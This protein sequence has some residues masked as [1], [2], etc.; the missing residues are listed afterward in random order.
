[1]IR[2]NIKKLIILCLMPLMF[3][4]FSL[5]VV[6]AGASTSY[7]Y[8]MRTGDHA[9]VYGKE[10]DIGGQADSTWGEIYYAFDDGEVTMDPENGA[11]ALQMETDRAFCMCL[12][13]DVETTTAGTYERFYI[14]AGKSI[15]FATED[16]TVTEIAATNAEPVINVG[17]GTVI[18][19]L[20]SMASANGVANENIDW[21]G[22]AKLGIISNCAYSHSFHL[23]LGEVGYYAGDFYNSSMTKIT[24]L[25]TQADSA[26][27]VHVAVGSLNEIG[28]YYPMRTGT[29][30]F[31]YGQAWSY[32]SQAE[33]PNTS[34]GYLAWLFDAYQS[35]VDTKASG[36]LAMQIATDKEMLFVPY[37]EAEYTDGSAKA[38]YQST[39]ST[40][41]YFVNEKDEVE[42]LTN[43]NGLVYI[44]A[45]REG[46]LLIPL[47]GMAT[48][49]DESMVNLEKVCSCGI[50][51]DAYYSHHFNFWAGEIGFYAG[52]F[53]NTKISKDVRP[54]SSSAHSARIISWGLPAENSTL[55][56]IGNIYTVTFKN[57]DTV[58]SSK[59]YLENSTV[60]VP[61]APTKEADAVA[62]Y[63][64]N[65][66]DS[67][68]TAATADKV[69]TAT[70]TTTYVDYSIAY[71]LAGGSVE[72]ENALT[73]NAGTNAITLI[74][75]TKEGYTF[76]G[77][78][79]T[80]LSEP[81]MEVTVAQGSTGDRSYVA[82]WTAN[83]Y[84]I[85]YDLDGGSVDGE[86]AATYTIE[87]DAITLINPTKEG[88]TFAGWTG[89]DLSE[90]TMEV[91]VAQGS[92]GDRSYVAT[93]TENQD[94]SDSSD[95]S[96][97]ISSDTGSS[98]TTSDSSS[99]TGSSDTA[100][101]TT[102]NTNSDTESGS[103]IVEP[104]SGCGASVSG[105][106]VLALLT[107]LGAGFAFKK[108]RD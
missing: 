78:T 92:T 98:D 4:F 75:P 1:M 62:S 74:N 91:T 66:W 7:T 29:E 108:K 28:G 26:K 90:P 10:W 44:P 102:S 100:S 11:I 72:G 96:S 19:P 37:F 18:I 95:S 25:A 81:T 35:I 68:V 14:S 48:N 52:D 36:Y 30:A 84:T 3:A 33:A 58:L 82:T 79:G 63:E 39:A 87:S 31:K 43:S 53:R 22:V 13:I 49:A 5:S 8:A 47:S 38:L 20:A 42:E 12:Y 55:T 41:F 27:I 2:K 80:D 69:Y 17:K 106:G 40:K 101:D 85:S 15:Y 24:T 94:S 64:F 71:D 34:Y 23:K 61:T 105:V 51:L 67:E 104:E 45:A 88:Y 57:G 93:W 21:T 103:S 73:Y 9:F 89:T 99:D 60:V 107:V 6:L 77:W 76:A 16:G 54:M 56:A 70:Y 65:G 50:L 83:T 59:R 32:D 97:D 86:N 46:M